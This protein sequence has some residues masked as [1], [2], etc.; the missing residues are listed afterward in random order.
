MHGRRLLIAVVTAI[1]FLPAMADDGV[2]HFM[3]EIVYDSPDM[4]PI[5]L[6]GESRSED[7]HAALYAVGCDVY[8][9]DGTLQWHFVRDF[10]NGTHGWVEVSGLYVPKKPV[11]R[12]VV[13]A[14]LKR[15][16][17]KARF[18]NCRVERRWPSPEERFG[19][20]RRTLAPFE[21]ADELHY[22]AYD[23]K[24]GW[25]RRTERVPAKIRTASPLRPDELRVWTADPFRRVTP[26]TF[27]SAGEPAP[28]V[29]LLLARRETENAQILVSAGAAAGTSGLDLEL[30]PPRSRNGAAFKG[31][32]TWKRQGYLKRTQV[33]RQMPDSPPSHESWIADPLLPPAP[34]AVPAGGTCGLWL[35]AGAAEDC[36][37]GVYSSQARVLKGGRIVASVPIELEVRD[38][39]LPKRFSLT[40]LFTSF[41]GFLRKVYGNG[42][43]KMR[44]S[45]MDVMLDHRLNPVDS[46][47]FLPPDPADV[48]YAHSRGANAACLLN[49]VPVPANTN[50]IWVCY[51]PVKEL[52]DPAFYASVRRRIDPVWKALRNTP[53]AKDLFFY[54]F[55]ERASEFYPVMDR[56][57]RR[58]QKDYPGVPLKTSAKMYRDL[59]KGE[60][61]DLLFSSDWFGPRI[62]VWNPSV[63]AELKARGKKVGFYVSEDPLPPWPGVG[64]YEFH[65]SDA[66][67]LFWMAY[68]ENADF[69]S[70]WATD[71]WNYRCG[72][73]DEQ[74]TFFPDFDTWNTSRMSGDGILLYPGRKS[75]LPSIRLAQLRD[76]AED[77]EL[78]AAY[79]NKYGREA[80]LHHVGR[81]VRDLTAFSRSAADYRAVR[82]SLMSERGEYP[83]R[84]FRLNCDFRKAEDVSFAEGIVRRAAATGVYNGVLLEP[85]ASRAIE[86]CG[87]WSGQEVAAFRKFQRLCE[88]LG[89]E[90]VPV[91]WSAGY[92]FALSVHPD[93][94]AALPVRDVRFRRKGAKGVF[95]PS[96]EAV[97]DFDRLGGAYEFDIASAR[98]GLNRDF[99]PFKASPYKMFRC[100]YRA[101]TQDLNSDHRFQILF[102]GKKG[103]DNDVPL[104]GIYPSPGKNSDWFNAQFDFYSGESVE[105]HLGIGVWSFR[106]GKAQV[107]RI[108]LEEVAPTTFLHREGTPVSVRDAT[109][110]VVYK[111]GRD[112]VFSPSRSPWTP[113]GRR[114]VEVSFP[115]GSRVPEGACIS[116]DGY[117]PA[118]IGWDQYPACMATP[119]LA[120]HFADSARDIKKLFGRFPRRVLLSDDETRAGGTCE[121]CR[122][123]GLDMA[124]VYARM[125]KAQRAAVR[126]VSPTTEM[127]IWSD[128]MDPYHNAKPER[129][130]LCKGGYEGTRDLIPRDL[131]VACWLR[132]ETE[133][134]VR[135]FA[136]AGFATCAATYYDSGSLD[137]SRRWLRAGN[138]TPGFKGL[139]YATWRSGAKQDFRFLEDFAAMLKHESSPVPA[140][141][142]IC[143]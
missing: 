73:I 33:F 115:D 67:I 19:V 77:Y 65:R 42:W 98:G 52:E 61:G 119:E 35:E 8:F 80:A 109:S 62:D 114:C 86:T 84:W 102:Y 10:P 60:R 51:A 39:T 141:K 135:G 63:T 106:S 140:K 50:A 22:E 118:V 43:E 99:L 105:H 40:T 131:T 37:P 130:F 28:A 55:D 142:G 69:L 6:R 83:F 125:V 57:W 32:L 70:Y 117:V 133:A 103:G 78:L 71:Y 2:E 100:R 46:S 136:D 53:A 58:L 85:P 90:V 112:V 93:L 15:G 82:E 122:R 113:E 87:S 139:A 5:I 56:L 129:Y 25:C 27:P 127:L 16:T 120:K 138:A 111:E 26:L 128:M 24:K 7:A 75:I 68:R 54:G 36:P 64:S 95:E 121:T 31:T 34:F 12:L 110:G 30:S 13:Y 108:S 123:S 66:R 81:M 47:R 94:A 116:V 74:K 124:H 132:R 89:I 38:V 72:A 11:R 21:D 48:L 88:S 134:S 143:K 137:S 104:R 17:G 79:G 23:P 29:S 92:G 101:R 59:A 126:A 41:D 96:R 4:T 1:A 76:G 45:M 49:I 97:C 18:R 91:I 20:Q 3:Q 44:R 9:A 107:E 14:A